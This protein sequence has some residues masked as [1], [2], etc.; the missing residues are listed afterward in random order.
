M[1]ILRSSVS[2]CCKKSDEFMLRN[3][4]FPFSKYAKKRELAKFENCFHFFTFAI[5]L[6]IYFFSKCFFPKSLTKEHKNMPI[7]DHSSIKRVSQDEGLESITL[8]S[9]LA[10]RYTFLNET[11]LEGL[12]AV[13]I[14]NKFKQTIDLKDIIRD[15]DGSIIIDEDK[16]LEE[17]EKRLA[18]EVAAIEKEQVTSNELVP[19]LSKNDTYLQLLDGTFTKTEEIDAVLQQ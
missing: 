17:W 8:R 13:K 9:D 2:V 16:Y 6:C 11:L 12:D 7:I 1:N 14:D 3:C 15:I 4:Q 19:A 18:Q 10:A 5:S